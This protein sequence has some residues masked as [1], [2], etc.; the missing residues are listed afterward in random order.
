MITIFFAFVSLLS[1][2]LRSRAGL[3]IERDRPVP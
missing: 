2:R 3:E 1:F